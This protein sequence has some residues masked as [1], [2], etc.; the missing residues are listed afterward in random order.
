MI[1]FKVH[2]ISLFIFSFSS[3]IVKLKSIYFDKFAK[4]IDENKDKVNLKDLI[5]VYIEFF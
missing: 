2:I 1:T 3:R 4:I 5:F